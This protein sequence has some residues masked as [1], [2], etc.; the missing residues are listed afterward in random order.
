M[1]RAFTRESKESIAMIVLAV[2]DPPHNGVVA[3]DNGG[4]LNSF[5]PASKNPARADAGQTRSALRQSGSQMRF[6]FETS[7]TGTSSTGSGGDGGGV[8]SG[9]LIAIEGNAGEAAGTPVA[10]HLLAG[11]TQLPRPPLLSLLINDTAYPPNQDNIIKGLR[12]GDRFSF[13][14]GLTCG[15]TGK[16]YNVVV[17]LSVQ[18]A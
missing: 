6:S 8:L 10:L 12:V 4:A 17:T 14:G 18:S 16:P 2:V 15:G 9:I 5:G 7:P 3:L 11:G 13:L 1:R